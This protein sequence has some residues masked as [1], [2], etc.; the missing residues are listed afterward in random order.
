MRWASAISSAT[1]IDEAVAETT[2]ALAADLAPAKADLV[3]AFV[4]DH[5][6]AGFAHLSDAIAP[7]FPTAVFA[8]CT[9]GGAIGGGAEIE[10]RA[11]LAL[12]AASLPDVEIGSH[13]LGSDPTTWP[14]RAHTAADARAVLV[15][16]CPLSCPTEELLAW[17]DTRW[18]HAVKIGGLASGGMTGHGPSGNTMFL[19]ADRHREGAVVVTLSGDIT[20]D[21][22][23][24]QGCRP[25]G[26]PMV[27][28][29]G[30]GNVVL[31]LD[32]APALATLERL[33][34]GLSADERGLCRHSLFIGLAPGPAPTV[35]NR[36]DVLIRN[37]I[38]C[39]RAASAIAIGARVT[40]GDVVQFHVRDAT[41]SAQDLAELLA[42]PWPPPAGALLFSCVGRGELLYGQPG[43]DSG[44]FQRALGP[45]PLG[46]FFCN[47]EVGPVGGQTFLHGHTSAFALFRR[48]GAEA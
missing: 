18:P 9:A 39:D 22:I 4:T 35:V 25:I 10:H 24:A 17:A 6:A 12:C 11:A 23:V 16:P 46:G 2:A 41:A 36:R 8:G 1:S 38:G 45:V 31:E 3:L 7:R 13:H 40:V 37:L 30:L 21:A 5:L 32:G 29:K 34:A 33:H 20:V 44:A 27:V 43:H 15:L 28:T 47:G 26:P 19:G 42:E 14:T 48:R